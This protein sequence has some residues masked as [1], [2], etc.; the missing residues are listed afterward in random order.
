MSVSR[1]EANGTDYGLDG[2][3]RDLQALS[4]T[5]ANGLVFEDQR[6]GD[7]RRPSLTKPT[8]DCEGC[9]GRERIAAMTTFVSRTTGYMGDPGVLPLYRNKA[10]PNYECLGIAYQL[11]HSR[12]RC[13]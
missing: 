3:F 7:Q 6:N 2:A 10:R 13:S 9:S 8:E 4:L 5:F 12:N 1:H 11:P